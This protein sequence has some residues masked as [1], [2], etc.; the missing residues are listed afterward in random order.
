LLAASATAVLRC[1][2]RMAD[3]DSEASAASLVGDDAGGEGRVGDAV[4][5]SSAVFSTM[6]TVV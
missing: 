4:A 2:S 1:S 6:A 3:S 5:E